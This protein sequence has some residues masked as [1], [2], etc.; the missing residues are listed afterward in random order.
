MK[1]IHVT[2][3]DLAARDASCKYWQG[4]LTAAIA[5]I[6]RGEGIDQ[7]LHDLIAEDMTAVEK[8]YVRNQAWPAAT[9]RVL[10]F[11]YSQQAWI[12]TTEELNRIGGADADGVELVV[13]VMGGQL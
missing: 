9:P 5:Q 6:K 4:D 8:V 2:D 3:A 10:H 12:L 1:V 13:E 11:D 7:W